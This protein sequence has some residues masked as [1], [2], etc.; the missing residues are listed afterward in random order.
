MTRRSDE[1]WVIF[2]GARDPEDAALRAT[3]HSYGPDAGQ[4]AAPAAT[5]PVVFLH[6]LVGLNEHWEDLIGYIRHR[7]ECLAFELPLLE[8]PMSECSIEHVTVITERFLRERFPQGCILVGNSFGGH[9]ALRLAIQRPQLIKGLVLAGSSGLIEKS[10]VSTIEIRPTKR[11]LRSK[12]EELYYD[13]SFVREQ[14]LDRAFASLSKRGG[15]RAMI[16]LSRSARKDVL[17]QQIGSIRCPTLIVWGRQDVV[18]PPEAGESFAKLIPGARII[19]I[20]NCG[21]VPMA[22]GTQPFAAGML[23]FLDASF[24]PAGG[25]LA[26]AGG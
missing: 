6:G 14:D 3:I 22:E 21:H 15:A 25:A 11:W 5:P 10:I 4:P 17:R 9:V 24:P 8:L 1:S 26:P 18:T 23:E 12:I 19:W 20:D 7:A 2:P 13:P 16:K